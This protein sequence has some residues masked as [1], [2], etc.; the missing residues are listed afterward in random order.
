MGHQSLLCPAPVIATAPKSISARRDRS[1]E[2]K[3]GF[4]QRMLP[5]PWKL[6]PAEARLLMGLAGFWSVAGLVVLASASWWV[7]LREMG[8]GGFY[9]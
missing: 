5:L 2:R 3:N 1:R 7:A 6:W 4:F 8:D 9:L